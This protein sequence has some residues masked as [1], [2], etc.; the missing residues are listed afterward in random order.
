MKSYKNLYEIAL[1]QI[2]K[3]NN[4]TEKRGQSEKE[5]EKFIFM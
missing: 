3:E 5:R 1:S 4:E 2:K